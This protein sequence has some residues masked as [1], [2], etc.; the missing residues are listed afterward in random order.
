MVVHGDRR[1]FLSALLTV[2]EIQL[3]SWAKENGVSGS[4]AEISQNPKLRAEV[5]ALVEQ[6]NEELASYETVKKFKILEQDFSIETGELTPKLSVKRKVVNS[7]YGA[8]FDEFYQD[9]P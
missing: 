8:A 1:K 4:Y 7:K 6:S 9:S 2:D 3:Q 5:E